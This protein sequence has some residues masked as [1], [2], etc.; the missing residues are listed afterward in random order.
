MDVIFDQ[1]ALP[2]LAI[3]ARSMIWSTVGSEAFD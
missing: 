3:A 2:P 1:A